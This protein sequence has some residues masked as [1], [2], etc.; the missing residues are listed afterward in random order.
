MKTFHVCKVSL[1]C[2]ANLFNF[3]S[4]FF[5]MHRDVYGYSLSAFIYK[6]R[7]TICFSSC[8]LP[9]EVKASSLQ[10]QTLFSDY[11]SIY[12]LMSI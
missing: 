3:K 1:D 5:F 12:G 11:Y 2:I 9:M 10:K 6:T 7:Q 8:L 4:V